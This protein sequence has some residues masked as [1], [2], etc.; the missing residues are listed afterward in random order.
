[1]ACDQERIA[2]FRFYSLSRRAISSLTSNTGREHM[3]ASP[4]ATCWRH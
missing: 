1:M 4:V 3:A 2:N